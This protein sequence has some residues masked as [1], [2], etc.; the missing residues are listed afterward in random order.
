MKKYTLF[1]YV[2]VVLLLTVMLVAFAPNDFDRLIGIACFFYI[3]IPISL[4]SFEQNLRLLKNKVYAVPTFML[5]CNLILLLYPGFQLVFFSTE[6]NRIRY[7]MLNT[8]TYYV[9]ISIFLIT[10]IYHF[11]QLKHHASKGQ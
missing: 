6:S 11:F 7:F 10:I 8:I 1:V 3:M 2:L 9:S 4:V 5:L